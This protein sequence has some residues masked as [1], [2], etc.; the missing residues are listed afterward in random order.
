[1]L[2]AESKRAIAQLTNEVMVKYQYPGGVSRF[3]VSLSRIGKTLDSPSW[4]LTEDGSRA[5]QLGQDVELRYD[6]E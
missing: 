3:V 6:P 5:R 4:V 1:M 2:I